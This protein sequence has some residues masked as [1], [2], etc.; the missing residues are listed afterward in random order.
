MII[1]VGQNIFF[2][3]QNTRTVFL[4]SMNLPLQVYRNDTFNL[5]E[6]V[7][8]FFLCTRFCRNTHP[9][10]AAGICAKQDELWKQVLYA[11]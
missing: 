9:R 8:S 11:S 3:T 10:K 6:R 1:T 4:Q 2:S 5:M 7:A